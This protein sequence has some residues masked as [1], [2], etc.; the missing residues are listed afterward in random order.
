M[1]LCVHGQVYTR[2]AG[3]EACEVRVRVAA[4]FHVVAKLLGEERANVQLMETFV[5]LVGHICMVNT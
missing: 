1:S 5:K 4:G 2:L 3:D